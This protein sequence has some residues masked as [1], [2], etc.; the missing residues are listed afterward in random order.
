[1]PAIKIDR[2]IKIEQFEGPFYLLVELLEGQ[3]LDIA[4]VP[5]A[6]VTDQYISLLEVLEEKN[7][8]ELVDFLMV[9]AKLIYLKSQILLPALTPEEEESDLPAR[10]EIYYTFLQAA[11]EI[12]KLINKKKF[13]YVREKP[14]LSEQT[15]FLP[16]PRLTSHIL[17]KVFQDL[18][19]ELEPMIQTRQVSIKKVI[20]LKEKITEIK[21]LLA[22]RLAATFSE[23]VKSS[24]DKQEVIVTFLALLELV[25]QRV[26][27]V[28][29]TAI[30]SEIEIS[31]HQ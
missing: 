21:T 17:A 12:D 11:R 5:L 23:L 8:E 13:C 14:I 22:E 27:R 26:L 4:E 28:E 2:P 18:I 16:P 1:M 31:K 30:Y 24:R 6:Q 20:S 19:L 3:K 7:P 15:A 29:Q 9:A 10:L 25:K